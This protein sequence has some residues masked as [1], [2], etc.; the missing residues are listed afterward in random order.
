MNPI[1]DP[2]YKMAGF[3]Q[4]MTCEK[5]AEPIALQQLNVCRTCPTAQVRRLAG[6]VWLSCGEPGEDRMNEPEP[7]CGCGLG[8]LRGQARKDYFKLKTPEG[9]REFAR[10]RCVPVGK[11]RCVTKC[12]Q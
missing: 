12:P 9:R 8:R 6:F 4:W 3:A 1:R 7:S 2:I 5:V 11:T 10:A